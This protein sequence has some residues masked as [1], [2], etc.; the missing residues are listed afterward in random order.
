MNVRE[1]RLH[2]ALHELARFE[3]PAR[4]GVPLA[5]A[6]EPIPKGLHHE[7]LLQARVDVAGIAQVAKSNATDGA[8]LA[9]AGA[10]GRGE[11]RD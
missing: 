4:V 6:Q 1:R 9:H 3:V 11:V 10:V 5:K 2:D 8:P 7:E